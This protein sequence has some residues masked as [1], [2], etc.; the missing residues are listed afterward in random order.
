MFAPYLPINDI[1]ALF[2]K[3]LFL[4]KSQ[5]TLSFLKSRIKQMGEESNMALY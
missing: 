3:S 5:P 1:V 2:F 4:A